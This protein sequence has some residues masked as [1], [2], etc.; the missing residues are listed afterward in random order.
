[1]YNNGLAPTFHALTVCTS[2]GHTTIVANL[3]SD[4][5]RA[6]ALPG[7]IHVDAP[8][9]IAIYTHGGICVYSGAPGIISLSPTAST[10]FA[11][12]RTPSG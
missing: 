4:I 7:A 8:G 5:F 11:A 1:M 3:S 10:S 9:A 6:Y 12:G 2:A